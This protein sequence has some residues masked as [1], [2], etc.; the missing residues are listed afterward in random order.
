MCLTEVVFGCNDEDALNYN[1]E[2][3]TNDGS[4]FYYLTQITYEMFA[5]GIVEFNSRSI[6]NGI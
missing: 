5:D 6:W 1:L 4:C 3:N 2:S